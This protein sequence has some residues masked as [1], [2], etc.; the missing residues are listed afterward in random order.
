MMLWWGKI[1][2]IILFFGFIVA[3][4]ATFRGKDGLAVWL[5]LWVL[6]VVSGGITGFILRIIY[7]FLRGGNV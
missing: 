4:D 6:T 5:G 7:S 1:T 2:G 3:A